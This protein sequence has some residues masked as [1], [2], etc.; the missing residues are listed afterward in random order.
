VKLG[1]LVSGTVIVV[2][3]NPTPLH[4]GKAAPSAAASSA[5]IISW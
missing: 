4:C 3:V 5:S 1:C 2:G